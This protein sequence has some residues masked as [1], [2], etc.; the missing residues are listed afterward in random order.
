VR[1]SAGLHFALPVARLDGFPETDRPLV[2]VVPEGRPLWQAALP[3]RALLALGGE[4]R[5][6]SSGLLA[7]AAHRVGIP[8][9]A[10]V[11][12]LNLATAAAVVLFEVRRRATG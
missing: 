9:E 12:S 3:G 8:M 10:R 11:S 4:R 5:G 2:A 7:A 1:G 6:L